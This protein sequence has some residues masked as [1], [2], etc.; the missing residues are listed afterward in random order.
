MQKNTINFVTVARLVSQKGIDRL[1][2]VHSKLI[3]EGLNNNFYVIGDGPEKKN[4]RN[5]KRK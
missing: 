4:T 1:V 5:D 2:N 3:K